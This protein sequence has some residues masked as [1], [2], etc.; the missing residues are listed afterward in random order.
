VPD[1]GPVVKI[2]L[3]AIYQT[4]LEVKMSLNTM[5]V[6]SEQTHERLDDQE[7]EIRDLKSRVKDLEDRRWPMKQVMAVVGIVGL[8]VTIVTYIIT[9]R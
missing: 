9:Q 7:E 3:D 5:L 6:R 4:L 8:I 1:E 2:G